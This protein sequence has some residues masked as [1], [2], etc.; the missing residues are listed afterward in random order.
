MAS[1][2][3]AVRRR[4][5]RPFR[6]LLGFALALVL[7]PASL[8]A[9][10]Q[11]PPAAVP[12][13]YGHNPAAGAYVTLNGI[14]LYYETYGRG[15]PLLVV[16]GNGDSIAVLRKQIDFFAR[17]YEVIAADSRGHGNSDWGAVPLTY[18]LMA[19]D[20]NALLEK[21]RVKS[22]YVLGW[23]DGGILGLLLAIHHPD[24]V[25]KLAVMGANLEPS[26]AHDWAIQWVAAED[27][28]ADEMIARQDQSRPWAHYKQLLGLLGQQ[29]HIPLADLHRIA[30]PTLV[31]AGDK[32]VIRNE[33][34]L[35]IFDHLPKAH[36]C[37]F[38][39]AT[40]LIPRQDPALFN[41]T[42]EKFFQTP[43]ARPETK[44]IFVR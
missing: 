12:I 35:Q 44:D 19:E 31:M 22:V 25:G 11:P 32:D 40:H 5:K 18:E 38:P 8:C 13:P 4:E 27:R 16:H 10:D 9:A 39:G 1:M 6:P 34:T 21:R 7:A 42:V 3:P 37:I 2:Q 14:K 20:L 29:P 43:Y 30:A 17:D 28:R 24:K 41:R 23:S 26:G 15:R 33:H 36:L